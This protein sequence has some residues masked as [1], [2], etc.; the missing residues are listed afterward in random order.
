MNLS[1]FIRTIPDFPEPGIMFRDVTT[2][3]GNPNAFQTMILSFEEV[4]KG[5]NIDYIAGIDARG[6]IIGG[7]LAHHLGV[8]FVPVR[9]KGKLPY[10]TIEENYDLEYGTATLELHTDAVSAGSK[11]LV[12]DDL[13]A[14]GGTAIAAITLL[15]K[16]QAIL[17]GCAFL[18]DL[19][20]LEGSKKIIEMGI[21][22]RSLC[23]FDGE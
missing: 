6:F 1:Q 22:V 9:K 8:G 10:K 15:K 16:L 5:Q 23:A 21:E 17:V 7:A 2:L 11:V 13:I 3:F 12:V 20:D 18:V 4:W 19:P 14:T